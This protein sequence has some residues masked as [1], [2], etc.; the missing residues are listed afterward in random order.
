MKFAT[1][2]T[3]YAVVSIVFGLG[4]VLIPGPLLSIYGVTPDL[5]FR[6]IG[7]LFGAALVSLAVLAWSA[8]STV[9]AEAR[10]M[11]VLSLLVGEVVGLI[12]AIV[13]QLS[14][15]MNVL[16]WSVVLVYLVLVIGLAYFYFA[17]PNLVTQPA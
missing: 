5:S 17:R 15:A 8:R 11:A 6:Y 13:G 4:F 7:H 10:K 9:S 12:L 1:F 3:L 2:M 16:G 14:G